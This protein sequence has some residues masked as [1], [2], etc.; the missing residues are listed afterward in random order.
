MGKNAGVSE[1]CPYILDLDGVV[2]VRVHFLLVL[3]R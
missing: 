2:L 1:K 3:A